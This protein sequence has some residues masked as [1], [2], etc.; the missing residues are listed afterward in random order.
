MQSIEDRNPTIKEVI[1]QV[2]QLKRLR[3][4]EKD[5]FRLPTEQASEAVSQVKINEP[6]KFVDQKQNI[7]S[8][9]GYKSNQTKEA[10]KRSCFVCGSADHMYRHNEECLKRMRFNRN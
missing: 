2:T 8:M 1:K 10:K 6:K 5:D 3:E 7:S 4:N 9:I